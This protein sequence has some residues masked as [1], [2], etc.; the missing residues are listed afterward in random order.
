MKSIDE[1]NFNQSYALFKQGHT[2]IN[3][4][5]NSKYKYRQLTF[6]EEYYANKYFQLDAKMKNKFFELCRITKDNLARF[7]LIDSC[8]E[9]LKNKRI[10]ELD[11]IIS[12]IKS[13][14]EKTFTPLK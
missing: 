8:D 6:Y 12:H 14:G 7:N 11:N 2:Q 5:S 3:K 10:E 9:I 13:G 4:V 1:E